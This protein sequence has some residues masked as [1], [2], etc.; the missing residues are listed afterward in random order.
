MTIGSFQ[1]AKRQKIVSRDP[2]VVRSSDKTQLFFPNGA[3]YSEA[4]LNAVSGLSDNDIIRLIDA[5]IRIDGDILVTKT[6]TVYGNRAN[7]IVQK[8]VTEVFRFSGN[9]TKLTN[10]SIYG[11]ADI[12]TD[13]DLSERSDGITMAGDNGCVTNVTIRDMPASPGGSNFFSLH[14]T[15]GVEFKDCLSINP[16]SRCYRLKG[17]F[18]KALNC[19]GIITEGKVAR[20]SDANRFFGADSGGFNESLIIDGGLWISTITG[21]NPEQDRVEA[22]LDPGPG[23]SLTNCVVKNLEIDLTKKQ[24]SAATLAI[25]TSD[26]VNVTF[27]NVNIYGHPSA[28]VNTRSFVLFNHET[29]TI[30]GCDVDGQVWMFGNVDQCNMRDS[31]FCQGRP[32]INWIWHMENV[33]GLDV[34]DCQVGEMNGAPNVSIMNPNNNNSTIPSGQV[35]FL[36]DT[37]IEVS[38]TNQWLIGQVV[39]SGHLSIDNVTASGAGAD[40]LKFAPTIEES[41]LVNQITPLIRIS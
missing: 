5:D 38:A 29:V 19:V 41:G 22:V 4:I 37:I 35:V 1:Q 39:S 6:C 11:Q 7:F 23:N 20:G 24:T 32:T 33:S 13:F 30:T 17:D 9:N 26:I 34:R 10:F 28:N 8:P 16:A 18:G 40:S 2:I 31:K 27:E 36:K 14:G 21:V 12:R 3:D 15:S 25:K